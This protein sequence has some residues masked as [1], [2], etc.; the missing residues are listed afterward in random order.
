MRAGPG[1]YIVLVFPAPSLCYPPGPH[2]SDNCNAQV[3]SG[4]SLWGKHC[5][6]TEA[7]LCGRT[8]GASCQDSCGKLSLWELPMLGSEICRHGEPGWLSQLSFRLQLGSWSHGS[9][10]WALHQ[11]M[12]WQ[13]RAWSLLL[14]LW[15]PL[16]LP[17]PCSRSVSLCLSKIN[18][19]EK[20]LKEICCQER[21]L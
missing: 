11:A 7:S 9:W 13:L 4:F 20:K 17:L 21:L 5:G 14:I 16:S 10:V 6:P 1:F 3:H 2:H 8:G 19:C 18:K 15:L 12:C